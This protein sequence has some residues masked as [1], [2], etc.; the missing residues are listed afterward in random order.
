[1]SG[2]ARA[3]LQQRVS[4][5]WPGLRIIWPQCWA[6]G[7]ASMTGGLRAQSEQYGRWSCYPLVALVGCL[8]LSL[9]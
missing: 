3:S 2:L 6:V 8:L 1:M 4:G 5:A 9:I 7:M